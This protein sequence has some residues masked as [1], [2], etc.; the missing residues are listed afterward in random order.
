VSKA[1]S[2]S[3]QPKTEAEWQEY[4]RT[5]IG[6]RGSRIETTGDL[7]FETESTDAPQPPTKKPGRSDAPFQP[8]PVERDRSWGRE[9]AVFVVGSLIVAAILGVGSAI[10]NHGSR[11][12]RIEA[13]S[14]SGKDKSDGVSRAELAAIDQKVSWIEQ[15]LA[16]LVR[17]FDNYVDNRSG[18]RADAPASREEPPRTAK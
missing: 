18:Q 16:S 3:H 8:S 9:I 13:L 11:L 12:D 1:R 14:A 2:R 4:N 15:Q 7:P 6:R 10:L 17:R 5:V